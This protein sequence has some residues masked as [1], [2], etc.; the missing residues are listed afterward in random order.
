MSRCG[1][2][3]YVFVFW[4]RLFFSFSGSTHTLPHS[5]THFEPPR[6]SGRCS[7][8]PEGDVELC[9]TTRSRVH[10]VTNAVF[11]S[12]QNNAVP[13]ELEAVEP[14]PAV[15]VAGDDMDTSTPSAENENSTNDVN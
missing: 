6:L 11:R 13:V 3:I 8:D 10:P 12:L 4:R 14:P 2:F 5:H 7:R 15:D 9:C 1:A